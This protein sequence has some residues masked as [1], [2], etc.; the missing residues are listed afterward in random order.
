MTKAGVK[1][2]ARYYYYETVYIKSEIDDIRYNVR[3][4]LSNTNR[5]NLF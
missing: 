5:R 2:V 3:K 4:G 1:N